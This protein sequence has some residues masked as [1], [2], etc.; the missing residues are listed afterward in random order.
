MKKKKNKKIIFITCLI[1]F[2]L[3]LAFLLY[4]FF[5]SNKC[6]NVDVWQYLSKNLQSRTYKKNV[7]S[8]GE[9]TYDLYILSWS[10]DCRFLP[11]VLE[12]VGRGGGA[13][14]AEDFEPRGLYLFDNNSKQIKAI[15]K[16]LPNYYF[17]LENKSNYWVQGKY[18][19]S[20]SEKAEGQYLQKEYIYDPIKSSLMKYNNQ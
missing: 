1:V 10:K 2:V 15:K 19:F 6:A 17:N 3:I 20:E 9:A 5:Y 4:G 12:L 7:I 16:N 14:S 11:F 8:P 18:V 13:Y